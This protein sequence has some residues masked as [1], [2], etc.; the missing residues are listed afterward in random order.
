MPEA[1]GAR[2]L[3][4]SSS[5]HQEISILSRSIWIAASERH[6]SSS[7]PSVTEC[8]CGHEFLQSIQLVLEQLMVALGG[9]RLRRGEPSQLCL[10]VQRMLDRMPRRIIF[11]SDP[12]TPSF[13]RRLRGTATCAGD[14]YG[15]APVSPESCAA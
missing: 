6:S 4:F 7:R 5:S 3:V 14:G 8:M 13:E 9:G 12:R 11:G 1:T 10:A 2:P 15:I